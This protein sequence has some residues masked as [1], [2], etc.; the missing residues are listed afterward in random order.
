MNHPKDIEYFTQY[1]APLMELIHSAHNVNINATITFF[2]PMLYFLTRAFLCEK[3]LEIGHAEG[4]TSWYLANAIKD[5]AIRNNYK[6]PMYYGIDIVKTKEV[7]ENLTNAKLPNTIINMDSMNITPETFKD[8]QFDLIFQ[9]G[10]HDTPHV[11]HE[12]ETL[13]PQLKGNGKGYWIM[14]DCYGPAEDA[15]RKLIPFFDIKDMEWIRFDDG[16]YGIAIIRKME[17]Y[18]YLPHWKD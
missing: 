17:G 6:N 7:K 16:I 1:P 4:Y 11:I 2:G 8:I 18:S 5:N 15:F 14:H 3:V 12:I 9:D 10:A 13:W